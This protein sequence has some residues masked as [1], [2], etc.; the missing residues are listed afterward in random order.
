MKG[1]ALNVS[2]VDF[3]LY[4][5]CCTYIFQDKKALGLSRYSGLVIVPKSIPMDII[6][7]LTP[8]V[9]LL[10]TYFLSGL[11][12]SVQRNKLVKMQRTDL[13]TWKMK[14]LMMD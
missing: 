12:T 14:I 10:V 3:F 11:E 6:F 2:H 7:V 8:K 9:V 13:E 5:H 1:V 4:I